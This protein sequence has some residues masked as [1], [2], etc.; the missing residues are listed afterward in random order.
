MRKPGWTPSIVRKGEDDQNVYIVLDDFGR[1]GG[2]YRETD[3][4]R[5]DL[6]A[7]IMDMLEGQFQNP[8]RVIGFNTAEKWSQ[9]VSGNVAQELRRRSTCSS[10]MCRFS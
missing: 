6:K 3:A 4:E 7:V 2:A 9:D 5:S 1:K 8:V 10:V